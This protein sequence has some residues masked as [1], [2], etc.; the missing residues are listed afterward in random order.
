MTDPQITDN[1][2]QLR[3]ETHVDGHLAEL[4]Y[5]R[6]GKRLVLVHTSVPEEL[7]GR[8][9]GGHLVEAALRL[10]GAESLT[11][12]PLCPFARS[13]LE[14]HPKAAADATIDWTEPA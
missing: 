5:R 4:T 12:V 8:G 11:V 7:S 9:V 10:A 6:V 14:R 13:W 1:A 3:F 2:E